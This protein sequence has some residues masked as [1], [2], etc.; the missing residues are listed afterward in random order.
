MGW[1]GVA[2]D[3]LLE[4][5]L[6]RLSGIPICSIDENGDMTLPL[7]EFGYADEIKPAVIKMSELALVDQAARLFERSS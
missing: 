2:I 5:L 4:Y 6:K 1:F 7:T 3:P